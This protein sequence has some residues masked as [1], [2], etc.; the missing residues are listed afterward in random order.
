[1]GGDFCSSGHFHDILSDIDN[2]D[3]ILLLAQSVDTAEPGGLD[4]GFDSC[5]QQRFLHF[6]RLMKIMG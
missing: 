4:P 6:F 1:V 3:F 2:P 5:R